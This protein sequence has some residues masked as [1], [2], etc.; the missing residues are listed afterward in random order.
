MI[1]AESNRTQSS[2]T[3]FERQAQ[4]FPPPAEAAAGPSRVEQPP[5]SPAYDAIHFTSRV[6][7]GATIGSMWGLTAFVLA[8]IGLSGVAPVY[9]SSVAGIALGLAFLMLGG[10]AWAWALRFPLAEHASRWERIGFSGGVPA[11]LIA[12]LLGIV[13]S[14]LNL[15]YFAGARLGA[16]AVILLGLGLLWHSGVM[17]G[18]AR[19]TYHMVEGRRPSGPLAINP[20]SLAPVRDFVVGLG[21]LILGILAIL[22][23]APMVLEFV[24]LLA[25]GGAAMLTTSTICGATLADVAGSCSTAGCERIPEQ[26]KRSSS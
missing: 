24:A 2:V 9:M 4:A 6:A 14:I 7:S 11:V 15:T 25:M 19:F 10:V 17:L 5:A 20:L 18:V 3:S 16:V 13:L 12:G 26:S 22:N 21:S 1:T 8:I 23:I